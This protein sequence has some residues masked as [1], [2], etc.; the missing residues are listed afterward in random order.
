MTTASTVS[1]CWRRH[2]R[3]RQVRGHLRPILQRLKAT[4]VGPVSIMTCAVKPD[5]L[6]PNPGCKRD[7]LECHTFTHPCPLLTGKDIKASKDTYDKCVDLLASIPNNKPVAFRTPCCD[8]LNT[9]SPRFYSE[10]FNKTTP[11]KN[12]LQLDSSVFTLYTA[13]DPSIP[14]EW[15]FDADGREKFRKYIP[16]GLKRGDQV[17]DHFVNTIENYPYPYAIQN[18]CWQF[19]CM[20]PSDWSANHLQKPNNPDTVRDLKIALDITVMKQGVMNLVFHPHG[21]IK[22]E[23]VVELTI[24]RAITERRSSS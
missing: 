13:D 21:W 10:I 19:P 6:Q 7:C 20:V 1:L 24:T 15:L 14:R 3:T 5:D 22:A 4:T 23:Q 2:A 11:E 18:V 16:R 12:F 17:H 9:V 8:S